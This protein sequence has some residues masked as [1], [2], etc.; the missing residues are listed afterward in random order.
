[1]TRWTL[2][3]TAG[4]LALTSTTSVAQIPGPKALSPAPGTT[5]ARP[6]R[7]AGQIKL[8]Q[9]S[10]VETLTELVKEYELLAQAGRIDFYFVVST[11]GELV[12]A[13]LD[14]AEKPE[15]R[16]AL[17]AEKMKVAEVY[18]ERTQARFEAHR[19]TKSDLLSARAFL[20]GAEVNLLQ[21]RM[22]AGLSVSGKLP[23][24]ADGSPW[25][26]PTEEPEQRKSAGI[27]KPP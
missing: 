7:A 10:R 19:A 3:I 11:Q 6:H 24:P 8:L 23:I 17:L 4:V 15:E 25:K 26:V 13:K 27:P 2:L 12:D 9:K 14:L 5:S 20:L 16:A 21:E 18:W 22:T 1:M